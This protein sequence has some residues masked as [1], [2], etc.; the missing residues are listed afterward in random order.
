MFAGIELRDDAAEFGRSL[1]DDWCRH[2]G[3][4]FHPVGAAAEEGDFPVPLS[5]CA[6]IGVRVARDDRLQGLRATV[7]ELDAPGLESREVLLLRGPSGHALVSLHHG[8]EDQSGEAGS[9]LRELTGVELRDLEG[10]ATPE[11]TARV[12][13]YHRGGFESDRC[14]EDATTEE[15]LLVCAERGASFRCAS[16]VVARVHESSPR[17]PQDLYECETPR[18]E[19]VPAHTSG[20]RAQITLE[21]GRVVIHRGSEEDIDVR[22]D[23]DFEGELAFE[24]LFTDGGLAVDALAD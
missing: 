21:R 12:H 16:F 2:G 14:Y 20:F 13:E 6:D 8:L 24:A 17:P 5:S 9:Y 10:G 4:R 18:R 15:T 11:W 22:E 3:E 23:L 19:L 1:A 7:F